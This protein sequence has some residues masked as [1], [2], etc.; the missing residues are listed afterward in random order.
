[1]DLAG[2]TRQLHELLQTVSGPDMTVELSAPHGLVPVLADP[3]TV[4]QMVLNLSINARDAMDGRGHLSLTVDTVD[5][6]SER[7]GKLGLVPGAYARLSVA[8]DGPGMSDDVLAR[9][10][11]PF[12]TTKE[13]GKGSGL[14]LST[15][16][17]QAGV[18][19]GT[20]TIDTLLGVER[21]SAC[22]CPS[23][24]ASRSPRQRPP[25]N[26]PHG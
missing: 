4:E 3:A 20:L 14:G 19:G 6:D 7:A 10:L 9:C 22:R 2:A 15:V 18:Y 25:R 17:G 1:M 5:L 16:Y 12:F 21:P 11:E 24:P 23:P 8:D 13:R 26:R